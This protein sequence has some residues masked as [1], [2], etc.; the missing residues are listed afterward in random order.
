VLLVYRLGGAG[1]IQLVR[2]YIKDHKDEYNLIVWINAMNEDSVRASF[3]TCADNLRL[4]V[5]L[6][7]TQTSKLVASPA[8]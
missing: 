3:E 2:Q 4:R 7:G 6:K 8:V 1:K 5:N